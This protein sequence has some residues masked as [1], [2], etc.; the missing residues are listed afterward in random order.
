[1]KFIQKIFSVKNVPGLRGKEKILCILGLKIKF[2]S[3]YRKYKFLGENNRLIYIDENKESEILKTN[4]YLSLKI[5][6]NNNKVILDKEYLNNIFSLN[7]NIYGS[8]N[9]IQIGKTKILNGSIN[10]CGNNNS[11]K[12]KD[13]VYSLTFSANIGQTALNGDLADLNGRIDIGKNCSMGEVDF[14][15]YQKDTSITIGDE[16]MFSTG[17]VIQSHDGHKILNNSTGNLINKKK[18]N[19]IIGNHVWIGRG[20]SILKKAK[21]LDNSIVG[22]YSVVTREFFDK[23]IILAGNPAKVLKT[24]IN[25]DR[26]SNF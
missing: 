20:S 25:W 2:N 8:N 5:K 26:E 22:S 15:V 16:C 23:N 13:T 19:L 12:I 1:M 4:E 9:L 7:I 11:V 24:N 10:I 21:I 14:F 3:L 17:I 18:N 6:G